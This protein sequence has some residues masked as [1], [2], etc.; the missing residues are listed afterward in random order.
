MEYC[1]DLELAQM[2]QDMVQDRNGFAGKCRNFVLKRKG[3]V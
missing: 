3:N 1:R 2:Q